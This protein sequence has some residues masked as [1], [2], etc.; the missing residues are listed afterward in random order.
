MMQAFRR[1][2]GQAVPADF[3]R[4][5][6]ATRVFRTD[7]EF[8]PG[9]PLALHTVTSC[10]LGAALLRCES[11]AVLWPVGRVFYV[12]AGSVYVWTSQSC[13]VARQATASRPVRLSQPCSVCRWMAPHPAA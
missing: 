11:S 2:S 7:D 12:S 13:G 10:D 4:I 9:Q 3:D 8:D 1:W 5:L 6:P